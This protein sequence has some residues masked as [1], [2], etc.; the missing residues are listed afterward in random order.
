MLTEG[1]EE[2][3]EDDSSFDGEKDREGEHTIS[4]EKFFLSIIIMIT[5]NLINFKIK[6]HFDDIST[7]FFIQKL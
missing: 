5:Y 4:Y 6:N 2:E 1:I 3:E 7:L